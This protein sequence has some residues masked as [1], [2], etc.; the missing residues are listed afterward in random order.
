V[1][2]KSGTHPN[3]IA[4]AQAPGKPEKVPEMQ[5]AQEK[6]RTGLLAPGRKELETNLET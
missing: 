3:L 5:Q 4:R 6:V 1:R 2:T